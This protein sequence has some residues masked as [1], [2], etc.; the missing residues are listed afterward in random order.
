MLPEECE[1]AHHETGHDLPKVRRVCQFWASGF[2]K[3]RADQCQYVHG[4]LHDLDFTEDRS[5]RKTYYEGHAG[6]REESPDTSGLRQDEVE[7]V[8]GRQRSGHF[9]GPPAAALESHPSASSHPSP[10]VTVLPNYVEAHPRHGPSD[11]H[12]TSPIDQSRHVSI[13]Q[14]GIHSPSILI[15][16]EFHS[17]PLF[18]EEETYTPSLEACPA[19]T[20]DHME[21]NLDS[22][23]PA[24]SAVL[25]IS[26]RGSEG[27]AHLPLRL[28][29]DTHSRYKRLVDLAMSN[30][31]LDVQTMCVA[32][33]FDRFFHEVCEKSNIS[34]GCF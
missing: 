32:N 20:D 14:K 10:T 21:H 8:K 6:Q 28:T 2:C 17:P 24:I 15:E 34:C 11:D 26:T 30:T 5:G 7:N 25:R 27:S 18:N 31:E 19:F 29:L 4:D 16:E 3:Y 23:M 33:D 13:G 1:Y 22:M 12:T 9:R